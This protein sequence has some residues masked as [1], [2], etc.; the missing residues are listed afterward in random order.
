[1]TVYGLTTTGFVQKTLADLKLEVEN[2]LRASFGNSIDLSPQSVFGQLTGV[3]ADRLADLWSLGGAVHAAFTPDGASGTSLDD[4]AAITGTIRRAASPSEVRLTLSGTTGTT[5]TAGSV[6]TIGVAG[7][8][9][10]NLADTTLVAADAW[11]TSTVYTVGD[12]VARGGNIYVCT[13]QGTSS[14]GPSGTGTAIVDGTCTWRYMSAGTGVSEFTQ[15]AGEDNGP[16]GAVAY[17]LNT[18]GTP[19]SGWAAAINV[20]DAVL[21]TDLE[22]DA[23]LRIRREL[24]IRTSGKASLDALRAALLEVEDVT[25][26]KVFENP[27]DS[28]DVNGLPPHSIEA[29]VTGGTDVAVAASIFD[30][31]AAGIATYGTDSE[32]VTDA[33]GGVHVVYF[34][35]PTLVNVYVTY[36]LTVDLSEWPADGVAL[37]K[38]ALVA[39]GDAQVAGK[40][41][42]SSAAMAQ[43]FKVAGVLDGVAL[44]GTAPS[45]TLPTTLAMGPRQLAVY[46][47]SRIVVT[48]TGGTP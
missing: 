6:V 24:E 43:A 32:N 21:G 9:F 10:V 27:T 48:A 17:T 36:N 33:S 44:L 42:V 22:T 2:A 31:K 20:L 37:V 46:D 34:T 15:F 45:P 39:Y 19:T 8:R 47:T 11:A 23:A 5:I 1:M 28:T 13:V 29:L 3:M 4:L 38:A 40:D 18:I 26:A 25:S 16:L 41:V 14:A 35:R 30:E 7:T 12:A